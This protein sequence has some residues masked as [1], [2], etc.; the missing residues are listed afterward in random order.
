MPKNNTPTIPLATTAHPRIRQ[1]LISFLV[2]ATF[3]RER[4]F[5]AATPIG[6]TQLITIR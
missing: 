1:L 4:K 5:M 3:N 2:A 6:S